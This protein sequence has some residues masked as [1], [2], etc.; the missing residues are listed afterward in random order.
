MCVG[1][2][3]FGCPTNV[4]QLAEKTLW[5]VKGVVDKACTLPP[6][7]VP[8]MQCKL[9]EDMGPGCDDT[10]AI[11]CLYKLHSDL[12]CDEPEWDTICP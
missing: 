12:A 4:K 5:S 1:G 2:S 6:L 3:T 8:S 10:E 9:E 11:I 7:P